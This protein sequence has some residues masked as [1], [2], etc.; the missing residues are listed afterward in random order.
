MLPPGTL[1]AGAV[2]DEGSGRLTAEAVEAL[3]TLGAAGDLRGHFREAHV[4]IGVKGA[5]V[6]SAFEALGPHAIQVTVGDPTA[7]RAFELTDLT[8]GAR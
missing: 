2:G 4:F 3:R 5:S 1:V 8:L 7:P 6:G